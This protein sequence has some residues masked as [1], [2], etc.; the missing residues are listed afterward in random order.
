MRKSIK[1]F[2]AIF[3]PS[4]AP[5]QNNSKTFLFSFNPIKIIID[6][7]NGIINDEKYIIYFVL[8]QVFS[9]FFRLFFVSFRVL[10]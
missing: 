9:Y 10:E 8:R 6:K 7:I 1:S 4:S 2:I 3:I 5:L